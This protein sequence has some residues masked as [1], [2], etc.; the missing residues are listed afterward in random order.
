MKAAFP[1]RV[2]RS[3]VCFACAASFL[4]TCGMGTAQPTTRTGNACP[5]SLTWML[6]YAAPNGKTDDANERL[7]G[8]SCF[9]KSLERAFPMEQSFIGKSLPVSEAALYAVGVYGAGPQ[10]SEGRYITVQGCV[11]HEC[12]SIGMIWIDT[13]KPSQIVFTVSRDVPANGKTD[14]D[15]YHLW[16]YSSTLIP[17]NQQLPEPLLDSLKE[18]YKSENFVSATMIP[19][20]GEMLAALPSTLHLNQ[21]QATPAK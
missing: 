9:K 18:V 4:A 8:L 6:K 2:L 5:R 7:V 11:P 12:P 3:V 16:L 15:W 20:H 10:S 14:S 1:N 13:A 19:P 21:I 17:E